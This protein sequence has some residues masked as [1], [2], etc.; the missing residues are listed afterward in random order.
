MTQ[1][2]AIIGGGWSGLSAAAALCQG[3]PNGLQISLLEAAPQL[4]GRARGLSWDGLPIDNGQHLMLGAYES[5]RSLLDWAGVPTADWLS[6]GLEWV[7]QPFNHA[8]FGFRI[9]SAAWP[10]RLLAGALAP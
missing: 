2:L 3:Q 9:P 8:A 6:K 1:S 7:Y 10:M 4:G 5:T